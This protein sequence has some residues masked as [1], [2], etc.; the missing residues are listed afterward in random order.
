VSSLDGLTGIPCDSGFGTTQVVYAEGGGVTLTCVTPT[1][2]P[3]INENQAAAFNLGPALAQGDG[4]ATVT[5]VNVGSSE[6]WY[7]FTV[8]TSTS[9][10]TFTVTSSGTPPGTDV[11]DL[12]DLAGN[13]YASDV[14][15]YTATDL[16]AGTYYVEVYEA[17]LA[18]GACADGG[19]TLTASQTS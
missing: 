19:F 17:A 2:T 6:A 5:G 1:L 9:S 18:C 16:A 12:T 3:G 10:F 15:T 8:A 4:T 14:T 7:K 11:L 13:V